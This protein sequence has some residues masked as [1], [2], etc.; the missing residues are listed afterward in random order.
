MGD[1]LS[2]TMPHVKVPRRDY[3]AFLQMCDSDAGAHKRGSIFGEE[4]LGEVPEEYNYT[5]SPSDILNAVIG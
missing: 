1:I 4:P 3:Q 5:K 2:I